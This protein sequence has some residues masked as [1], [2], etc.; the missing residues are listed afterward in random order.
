MNPSYDIPT[1]EIEEYNN[2]EKS[3]LKYENNSHYSNLM[4]LKET[5]Y[6]PKVQKSS[7]LD[8]SEKLRNRDELK[9]LCVLP[10]LHKGPCQYK[11]NIFTSNKISQKLTKSINNK[12]Y[13]TPGNDDYVFKNRSSRLFCNVLSKQEE[14][15]IRDKKIK[16][17]C[18]IPLCDASTPKLLAQAYLDWMTYIINIDGIDSIL[19]KKYS[20]FNDIFKMIQQNKIYL[21]NEYNNREVFDKNGH[22]MCVIT[23]KKCNIEDFSDCER[24]NRN[25][26]KDSDIQMGHNE[27]R[28][29]N[30]VSIRG[31]NILP[32]SRR[33]NLIIGE[34]IFTK[35]EWI[36]E[37]QN[38]VDLHK[39][40]C[41]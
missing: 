2:F 7:Y 27:P 30:Y 12:I 37:L 32:Q 28:N 39:N 15:K 11:L 36:I 17:K 40:N 26:I 41:K 35:N 3:C 9:K 33:G 29:Y 13:N 22:T 8:N 20:M 38:I 24:D 10:K 14:K 31:G 1:E 6:G 18:A 5:K 34:K 19:N 23:K 16:K 21:I 25:N 4:C